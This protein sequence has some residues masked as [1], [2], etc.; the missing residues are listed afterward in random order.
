[1]VKIKKQMPATLGPELSSVNSLLASGYWKLV[2]RGAIEVGHRPGTR[3]SRG[4]VK[5]G[6][7]QRPMFPGGQLR[8]GTGQG[9]RLGVGLKPVQ[10]VF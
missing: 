3:V 6:I 2:S 10:E 4:Q 9:P 1:M 8:Q 7:G 5:Q